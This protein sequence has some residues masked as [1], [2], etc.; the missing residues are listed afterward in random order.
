MK[1]L[2]W[3]NIIFD[4]LQELVRLI[5]HSKIMHFI[6]WLVTSDKVLPICIVYKFHLLSVHRWFTMFSYLLQYV[7]A[8][9]VGGVPW[10]M[11]LHTVVNMFSIRALFPWFSCLLICVLHSS[12]GKWC[13]W[14]KQCFQARYV[15]SIVWRQVS[16]V[17]FNIC[18]NICHLGWKQALFWVFSHTIVYSRHTDDFL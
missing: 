5:Y 4:S 6:L 17:F 2:H 11:S 18:N 1:N 12:Q 14:R 10:F 16:T 9:V 13:H 8:W 7:V 3:A 15:T